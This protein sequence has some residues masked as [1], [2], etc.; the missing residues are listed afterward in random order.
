MLRFIHIA[1]GFIVYKLYFNI[2]AFKISKEGLCVYIYQAAIIKYH[3]LNG[4]HNK[5]LSFKVLMA[6]SKIKV[7]AD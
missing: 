4:I 1:R 3:T 2:F 7:L 5:H 6:K